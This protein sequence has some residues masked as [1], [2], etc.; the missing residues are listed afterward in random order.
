LRAA[1]ASR[2]ESLRHELGRQPHDTELAVAL[3]VDPSDIAEAR[4]CSAGYHAVSMDCPAAGGKALA[5]RLL[6]SPCTAASYVMSDALRQAMAALSDRE[7]L[8]LQL[9]FVDELTQSEIGKRIGASQMQVCRILTAIITQLR[10]HL[11]D[12]D[13]RHERA[14]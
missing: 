10:A 3:G 8:V 9:R 2:E 5:D 7:L 6:A 11:S 1:L 14:A 4:S 13:H 12:G